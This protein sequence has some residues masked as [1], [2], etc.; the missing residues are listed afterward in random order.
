M[1][2]IICDFALLIIVVL[3]NLVMNVNIMN[4][5]L[6]KFAS[7]ITK[8]QITH[9]AEKLKA[10]TPQLELLHNMCFHFMSLV[11]QICNHRKIAITYKIKYKKYRI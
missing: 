1:I 2:N 7:E 3:L 4:I 5:L 6:P 11:Y 8:I 9:L 10:I